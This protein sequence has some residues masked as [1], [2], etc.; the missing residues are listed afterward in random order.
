MILPV[1]SSSHTKRKHSRPFTPFISFLLFQFSRTKSD[2][3]LSSLLLS[4][5]HLY[6]TQQLLLRDDTAVECKVVGNIYPFREGLH[7]GMRSSS[8]F[9]HSSTLLAVAW[10]P[11]L[12]CPGVIVILDVNGPTRATSYN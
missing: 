9:F 7:N 5:D 8:L 11:H 4:H 10:T 3:R 6:Y 1:S 12:D 2:G